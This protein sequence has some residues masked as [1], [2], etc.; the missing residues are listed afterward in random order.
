MKP[1]TDPTVEFD[2]VGALAPTVADIEATSP[3]T[4]ALMRVAS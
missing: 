2:A 1:E 3:V 4:G